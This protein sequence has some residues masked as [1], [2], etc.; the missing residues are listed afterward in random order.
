MDE[1]ELAGVLIPLF[2]LQGIY[3]EHLRCT[4]GLLFHEQGTDTAWDGR[5]LDHAEPGSRRGV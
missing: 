2:L 5:A 3:M 4:S 1:D